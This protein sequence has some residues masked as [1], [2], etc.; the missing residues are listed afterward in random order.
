MRLLEGDGGGDRPAVQHRPRDRASDGDRAR[1]LVCVAC[2]HRI[3]DE[4]YRIEH[5][6]SHGHTF[7]NAAGYVHAIGCFA[8]APGVVYAGEPDTYFSWFPGWSWQIAECGLCRSHVGWIYRC[9]GDQF[10]GLVLD[11]LRP[12]P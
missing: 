7:V 1:P 11:R 5:G 4:A 8:L 6:G 3:T 12:G 10:H 2:G 9:A